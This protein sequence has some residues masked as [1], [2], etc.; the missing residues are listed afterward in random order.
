MSKG[1]VVQ[2]SK[3]KFL[4]FFLSKNNLLSLFYF[5]KFRTLFIF[6]ILLILFFEIQNSFYIFHINKLIL[7]TKITISCILGLFLFVFASRLNELC[8]PNG[9][10]LYLFILGGHMRREMQHFPFF[11]PNV[12]SQVSSSHEIVTHFSK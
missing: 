9:R 10:L 11:F 8:C 1:V 4:F 7:L 12:V 5:L 2:K 6:F 3:V